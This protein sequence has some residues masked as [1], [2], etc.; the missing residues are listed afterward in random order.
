MTS[1][2]EVRCYRYRLALRT[3]ACLEWERTTQP[4][5]AKSSS[6]RYLGCQLIMLDGYHVFFRDRHSI[7]KRIR[8]QGSKS[9]AAKPLSAA[10]GTLDVPEI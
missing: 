8:R 3:V 5:E 2:P 9:S 10:A 7:H 1:S 6:L 4:L